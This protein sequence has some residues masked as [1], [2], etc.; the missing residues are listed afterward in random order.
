MIFQVILQFDHS[1]SALK[2]SF[3]AWNVIRDA[4]DSQD[5]KRK[6]G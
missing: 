2:N 5:Y 4:I 3:S 1:F 6:N